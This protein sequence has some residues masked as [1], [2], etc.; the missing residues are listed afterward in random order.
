Q[1]SAWWITRIKRARD[2]NRLVVT[3]IPGEPIHPFICWNCLEHFH[4]V[5]PFWW[6]FVF[7]FLLAGQ[8]T[9]QLSLGVENVENY[10]ILRCA[11]EIIID[12]RAHRRV[13][14]GRLAFVDLLRVMKSHRCLR[15]V[16]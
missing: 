2:L 11:L 8:M 10:F 7:L 12:Y 6:L 1:R 9:N 4:S 5:R 3:Q 13:V 16:K 15:L 14:T